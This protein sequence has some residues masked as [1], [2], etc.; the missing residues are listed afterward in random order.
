[1][2]LEQMIAGYR[3]FRERAYAPGES[4]LAE[5]ARRGQSPKVMI[6]GCADSRVDPATI[7]GAEPG[8]LFVVRNV[9]NL[10]PPCEPDSAYHGTSAALEFAVE[11][12]GVENIVILGHT[13]C[14]GID[15]LLRGAVPTGTAGFIARWMAMA[16][17]ARAD[18]LARQ[19]ASPAEVQAR[20]LE[21]RS[22]VHSL[23][24]LRGFP[25]VRARLDADRLKVHG[26]LLDI[27][28]G[29]LLAYDESAGRFVPL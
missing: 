6:V 11:G 5:L 18:V 29:S 4:R 26:W 7:F 14:G 1:M 21:Q 2:T 8:D 17:P 27:A 22:I 20:A 16:E 19:A 15:A 28:D 24:N 25:F 23:D 12:L 3:A 10:I 13:L 9:A